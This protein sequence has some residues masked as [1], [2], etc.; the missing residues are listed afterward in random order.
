M[1]YLP[2]I[3]HHVTV[4]DKVNAYDGR[5]AVVTAIDVVGDVTV[6]SVKVG[7]VSFSLTRAKLR[8]MK[9]GA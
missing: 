1:T 2:T 9:Y 5:E 4:A 7:N 6:Y 3:G 8:E